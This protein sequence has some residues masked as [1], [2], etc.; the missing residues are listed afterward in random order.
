MI[1]TIR[2][3]I[4]FPEETGEVYEQKII[5]D[6]HTVIKEMKNCTE[7]SFR[8]DSI[9][10]INFTLSFPKYYS[11]TNA[12]LIN[13]REECL[14]V[15]TSFIREILLRLTSNITEYGF[16]KH[17]RLIEWVDENI[18]IKIIRVDI[19]FTYLKLEK[20]EFNSYQNIFKFLALVYNKANRRSGIKS[21]YSYIDKK[22]ETLTLADTSNVNSANKKISIYN[23]SKKIKDCYGK[24]GDNFLKNIEEEFPDL[25]NRIR[26][27]ASKRINRKGMNFTKFLEFDIYKEYVNEFLEYIL[28]NILNKE[29]LDKVKEESIEELT[30]ILSFERRETNFDARVF[31]L[32]YQEKILSFDILKKVIM[33]TSSNKNT[34]Y[35]L[36]KKAKK[37]VRELEEEKRII[38]MDVEKKIQDIR[39]RIL[40]YQEEYNK[41]MKVNKFN[42]QDYRVESRAT[43]SKL[44]KSF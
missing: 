36:V 14:K 35:T 9:S 34:G 1:D 5:R 15:Q 30:Q 39:E 10:E 19:P 4:I 12:Y 13:I 26:I 2:M 37:I 27:E 31:I 43:K 22:V 8:N 6:I 25:K 18:L 32:K 41:S 21:I 20:E 11:K 28:E 42:K 3:K 16:G 23:Q 40:E 24:K 33:N 7:V 38:Y 29:I 17:S 44:L